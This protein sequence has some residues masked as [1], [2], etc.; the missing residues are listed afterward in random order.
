MKNT[1]V[2]IKRVR[3][4]L[5]VRLLNH[6]WRSE[7][8]ERSPEASAASIVERPLI[9]L[10]II[11]EKTLSVSDGDGDN[12]PFVYSASVYATTATG[13]AGVFAN[14]FKLAGARPI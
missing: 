14:T 7:L 1:R 4:L 10:F 2:V 11:P 8:K 3:I 5:V 12:H 6:C 13:S 9:T